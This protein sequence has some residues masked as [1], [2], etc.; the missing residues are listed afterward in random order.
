MWWFHLR[1]NH[2]IEE[3][4][5]KANKRLFL[6]C[7]CRKANLPKDVGITLYNTKIRPLLEY[8]SPVWGGLPNYLSEEV[9]S[10]SSSLSIIGVP[11]TALPAL[12]ERRSTATKQ[13]FEKILEDESNPNKVFVKSA[14][15]NQYN[16]R[17]RR[18][19]FI[20]IL[21]RAHKLLWNITFIYLWVYMYIVFL[22]IITIIICH[23]SC[24]F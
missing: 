10:L 1:W 13:E 2:H 7:E 14:P 17:S 16:L 6:L 19:T 23:F 20:E 12:Y 11:R 21:P 24:I 15:K 3:M 8:G 9:H 4:T 18:S 22:Y 5:K